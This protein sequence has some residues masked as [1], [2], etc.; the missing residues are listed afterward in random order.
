MKLSRMFEDDY[1]RNQKE[2]QSRID[3]QLRHMIQR[4]KR[5]LGIREELGQISQ[6]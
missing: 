1:N 4:K 6:S 3:S 2:V 5:E